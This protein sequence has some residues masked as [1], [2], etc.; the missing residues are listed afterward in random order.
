MI[1]KEAAQVVSVTPLS[2][3]R[4]FVLT[5]KSAHLADSARPGHFIAVAADTGSAILRKPF[6]VYTVDRFAGEI[7]IL[8][9][10]TV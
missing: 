8:F 4:H 6:S 10:D 9:S 2:A 5:M 1:K 7:S 3:P